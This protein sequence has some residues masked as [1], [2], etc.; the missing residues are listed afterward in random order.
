M[1]TSALLAALFLGSFFHINLGPDVKSPL[2]YDMPPAYVIAVS[3]DVS[4]SGMTKVVRPDTTWWKEFNEP[5]LDT[6]IEEAFRA[7]KDLEIALARVQQARSVFKETRAN[8]RPEVG[9]KLDATRYKRLGSTAGLNDN[10]TYNSLVGAGVINYE[11]D[12]WGKLQKATRAAKEEILAAESAKN[13]IRLSLASQVAKTY[14]SLRAADKQLLVAKTMLQSQIS[15]V[16]LNKLRYQH[17]AIGELDLRRSEAEAASSAA[18]VSKLE[19]AMTQYENSLLLLMG[20]KPLDYVS[21]DIVRGAS[22]SE[23]PEPPVVPS[24]VPADLLRQRPDI[25]EAEFKYKS[26]LANLGSARAGQ[27][28]AISFNGLIGTPADD[29]SGLFTG[30]TGWSAASQFLMPIFNSGKLSSRVRQ[31]EAIAQQALAQY[32]KTVQ[33]AFAETMNAL[34][35]RDKSA[36]IERYLMKQEE[37][38]SRAY[39]LARE[40]YNEGATSQLELLDAERQLL[41]VRLQLESSRADRLNAIVDL[42]SSL[43]GGWAWRA[44]DDLENRTLPKPWEKPKRNEQ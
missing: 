27:Y 31:R 17:G 35:A 14:F 24:G 34:T 32:Y 26:S 33:A 23:L 36:E 29:P 2:S 37:V 7:N 6:C 3:S 42:C 43:G 4:S 16:E 44:A 18:Q 9:A 41:S 25:M 10:E 12:L 8:Q 22:L 19:I 20:R 5:V 21:R 30:A 1:T 11:A 15:T 38:Q 40:R 13:S 39:V 28:P